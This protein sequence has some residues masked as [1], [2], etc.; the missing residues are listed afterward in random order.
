MY[1]DLP[2]VLHEVHENSEKFFII[3]LKIFFEHLPI[4]RTILNDQ[5]HTGETH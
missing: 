1:E 2:G 5:Y 4:M 3:N